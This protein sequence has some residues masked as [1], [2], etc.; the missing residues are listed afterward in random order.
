MEDFLKFSRAKARPDF[1]VLAA[2]LKRP[3][4]KTMWRQRHFQRL[5]RGTD[6]AGFCGTSALVPC[7]KT[8]QADA[9]Q[10]SL[11]P[12]PVT[13]L[14]RS[15][16]LNALV[17]AFF[18]VL[19]FTCLLLAPCAAQTTA[20]PAYGGGFDGDHYSTLTQ[21]DRANVHGLK[22]AW[23]FDTGEKGNLEVN[24]L[25][26][27]RT[28]Y[29]YTASETVIAL[30]AA[31]GKLKWKF[32]S[33]IHATQPAR[34][35]TYWT[36]GTDARIFAGVMNFLFC[37][38]AETGKPI[39]TFGKNGRIDLR[40]NLRGNPEEQSVALTTP[41]VVYKDLIIVGGRNPETHPAPPGDIRA[42]DVHTGAM[43]WAFHTIPRPGEPGSETWPADA[44]KTAGAANDWAGLSLD[45]ARGV[46]YVPTGSAV[47]DFYG[48]DRVGNDL[49]ANC[50]LALDAATGKL[51][52]HFQGVHHDI[53]DRDFPAPP[54]LYTLHENG[55]TTE[56]LAQ[57]SKQAYVYLFNR[58][59]GEPLFPIHEQP[60]PVSSVPGEVT[61]PTQPLPELPQ[62]FGRQQLTA[63]MLTN[64]TPEA[65][66]WA[67]QQFATLRSGGQFYPF[68]VGQQ[69][70]VFP[71]YDG[72][73]EWSGP[74]LDPTTGTLYVGSS[75]MAWLGG[76][77]PVAHGG[78]AG[79]RIYM[80]QCAVCH[81]VNRGG[82]PPSF[83]SLVGAV[84]QLGAN[85]VTNT[86]RH[87]SGRMPSFP[88]IVDAKLTALLDFLRT[89]VAPDAGKELAPAPPESEGPAFNSAGGTIYR[90]RCAGCHGENM[91]GIPPSFPMLRG[92][93][94]RLTEEQ[95]T[96]RIHQGKGPMPAMP[97]LVGPELDA[98]LRYLGVGAPQPSAP[99][100]EPNEFVFTGYHKFLDPDG[101]PAIAPPWGTLN[102]IDLKTG[103]Y[104]WKIPLGEYPELARQGL[105]NTGTEMYGGPIVTAGGVLFIGATVYDRKFR[106]FDASNGKLLWETELP[107]AGL[108]TPSTYMV[109]G[110]Q[111]V[112]IAA[113][114][115]RDPNG[116]VGGE[117][118]AFALPSE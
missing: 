91:E 109:D 36:D 95:I 32:D 98:L 114:G 71:G 90:D 60:F 48:G 8:A 46:V 111:Y 14:L 24:P 117:Y 51:L 20:W 108:A 29:A 4:K 31:T 80:Q 81:G 85:E 65:H 39:A 101:Y 73:G 58:V 78:S 22:L 25:I 93:A 113:S 55:Q 56:A 34:G 66:A 107:F 63:D 53:W 105:K 15:R 18:C 116:P 26:V 69:T 68:A 84:Q 103:K 87:G 118:V 100:K 35:V 97:D 75:E 112:V 37:L 106:A 23:S 67:V 115:G 33:G 83:P 9:F 82:A 7:Y 47:M 19:L 28:L 42:Y 38:D 43:R 102:A 54:A 110:R 27:G 11:K 99:A 59:T 89:P 6:F 86:I 49:Y 92:V 2:R 96:T 40:E 41:G 3:L 70:V 16:L 17:P 64:R 30:D 13:E 62:P 50:I 52:W 74:A 45:T 1:A 72:G 44:W 77:I 104:L 21:I 61:S 94:K 57:I 79:E 88:N 10:H 12:R 5:K 76:L